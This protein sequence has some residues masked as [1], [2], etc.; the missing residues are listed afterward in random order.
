MFN[1]PDVSGSGIVAANSASGLHGVLL[2]FNSIDY[3]SSSLTVPIS[4]RNDR[5]R[6]CDGA[7]E[8]V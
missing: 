7:D 1:R 3:A 6:L 4:L 2:V 8:K 5:I